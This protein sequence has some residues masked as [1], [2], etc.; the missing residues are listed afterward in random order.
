MIGNFSASKKFSL[1]RSLSRKA[2]LVL[3]LLVSI[4]IETDDPSIDSG[5]YISVPPK[6]ANAPLTVES[7][8]KRTEKA[9]AEC[10]QSTS[11]RWTESPV[12]AFKDAKL[13]LCAAT[14]CT[15]GIALDMVIAH[16]MAEMRLG[17]IMDATQAGS[18]PTLKQ[19]VAKRR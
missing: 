7:P 13:A 4:T 5:S 10:G 15:A 14:V 16:A 3:M 2:T 12:G 11:K 9:N 19:I 8:M 17:V 18:Q 6:S 1:F